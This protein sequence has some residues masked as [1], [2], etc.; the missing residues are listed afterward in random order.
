MQTT[1]G[2]DYIRGGKQ[3]ATYEAKD[4]VAWPCPLCGAEGGKTLSV[5]RGVLG[6]QVCEGCELIRINPRLSRPDEVYRGEGALY[7]AEFREVVAGKKPHHRDSN[8]KHDLELIERLKPTGNFLDIGTNAGSF[9][10]LARDRGWKLTGIEPSP[11]LGALARRWWGL[12]ILE[13]FIETMSLPERHYDVVTMTDVFEHVVNPKEVLGAVRKCIKPDGV[14]F[15]KVPNALFNILKF[16]VRSMLGR[17]GVNDFDAY[18]HVV[19]YTDET[20]A[21]MLRACGFEPFETYVERPVQLPVWHK[22]VGHYYQHQ[23][24]FLLDWKTYAARAL[25]Y[26]GALAESLVTRRVG[27]LAPNIGC[28]ARLAPGA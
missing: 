5:E 8:Y 24:P 6:V 27:W 28:F 7:E 20:L 11:S 19:H 3:R 14:L 9:L 26:Q 23:S 21:K 1:T 22:Y 2:D 18:E 25:V 13:G 17:G 10:R 15:I 16:R 12:E 4:V